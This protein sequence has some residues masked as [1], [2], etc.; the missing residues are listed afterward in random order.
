MQDDEIVK[1]IQFE[2]GRLHPD[3]AAQAALKALPEGELSDKLV[4]LEARYEQLRYLRI[5]KQRLL[6][7]FACWLAD[8]ILRIF[9]QQIALLATAYQEEISAGKA[10]AARESFGAEYTRICAEQTEFQKFLR[11]NFTPDL[12]R[13]QSLNV[14]LLE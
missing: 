8:D 4:A 10:K 7:R 14:S 5:G 6:A 11:D 12:E 9:R 3:S 2:G 1:N 13:A